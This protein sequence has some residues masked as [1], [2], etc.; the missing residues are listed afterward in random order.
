MFIA[1]KLLFEFDNQTISLLVKT[2]ELPYFYVFG[3]FPPE[4]WVCLKWKIITEL[5]IP[6]GNVEIDPKF[7]DVYDNLSEIID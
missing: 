2:D 3:Y 4:D 1:A 5:K 7:K 6:V